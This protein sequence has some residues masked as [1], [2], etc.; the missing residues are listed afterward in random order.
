MKWI[1]RE[2]ER[3]EMVAISFVEFALKF[4]PKNWDKRTQKWNVELYQCNLK[5]CKNADKDSMLIIT[6]KVA[7][8]QAETPKQSDDRNNANINTYEREQ[9]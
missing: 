8:N 9:G 6:N 4:D 1:R 2:D 7:H 3:F 5:A